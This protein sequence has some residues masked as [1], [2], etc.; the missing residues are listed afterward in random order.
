M[1]EGVVALGAGGGTGEGV[2]ALGAGGGTGEG[3][4]AFGITGAGAGG[5]GIGT[6]ALLGTPCPCPL[7]RTMRRI[8]PVITPATFAVNLGFLRTKSTK[9]TAHIV[10]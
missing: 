5:V 10:V 4:V 9:K 7:I 2:V 1:G 6:G 3:V 8:T